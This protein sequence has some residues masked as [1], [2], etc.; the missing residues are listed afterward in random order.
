MAN[1]M[2]KQLVIGNLAGD[3]QLVHVGEKNTPKCSFRVIA[4][5]GWADH[6]HAEGF[7]IVVWAKRAEGIVNHLTRGMRV[8]V[9][10]ETRTRSWEGEDGQRRYRTEVV[11]SE[12][13]L[14]GRS[15]GDGF[16]DDCEACAGEEAVPF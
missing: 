13:V 14:L 11:A 7:D 8:Y 6:Q 10:G 9:E 15:A 12:I 4:N 5:T 3:A 16:H 2:N 1:G